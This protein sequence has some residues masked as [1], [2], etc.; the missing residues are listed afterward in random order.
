MTVVPQ[1]TSNVNTRRPSYGGVATH[2]A[3]CTCGSEALFGSWNCGRVTIPSSVKIIRLES[4]EETKW[5]R[6]ALYN[7][8]DPT[9]FTW[10]LPKM[11]QPAISPAAGR[12]A[13]YPDTLLTD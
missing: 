11:Q 4:C 8:S 1:Y 2:G 5:A 13:E 6:S 7:S 3:R 10:V 9:N 12:R